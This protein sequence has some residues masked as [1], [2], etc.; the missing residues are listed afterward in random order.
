MNDIVER[1]NLAPDLNIS[2]VLTGL[3]QIADMEREGRKLDPEA[4]AS[5]FRELPRRTAAELSAVTT[6]PLRQI[7]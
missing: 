2:R 7:L 3:W 5:W 4:T 6:R 1:W